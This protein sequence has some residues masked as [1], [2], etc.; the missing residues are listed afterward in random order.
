MM[1]WIDADDYWQQ[2]INWPWCF[3]P[4]GTVQDLTTGFIHRAEDGMVLN[5]PPDALD[6]QIIYTDALDCEFLS[7]EDY[8]N[9]E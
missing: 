1:A 5:L 4:D 8:L 7:D 3:L 6:A 2:R 9:C